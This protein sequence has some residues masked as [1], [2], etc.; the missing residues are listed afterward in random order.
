MKILPR[1]A[2][3][4]TVLLIGLLLLINQIVSWVSIALYI[5]QPNSQ[6]IHQLLAKQVRVVFIDVKDPILSP[7]DN[8][9]WKGESDNRFNVI[10]KGDFDSHKVH[11][12][13][14]LFYKDKFYL[15]YKGEQ[16]RE[17]IT[18]GGRQIRH[19]PAIADNPLGP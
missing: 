3:G 11:D 6:Q 13:C 4:Q 14:L 2:F 9:I 12:P 17:E 8:G 18:F 5:I 10:K 1:S 15:Y 19:A 7:A 16:M